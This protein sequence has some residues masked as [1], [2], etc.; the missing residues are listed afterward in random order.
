MLVKFKADTHQY[1]DENNN[2]L[3]SVSSFVKEFQ[4]KVDWIKKAKTKSKNLLKY[5]GIKKDYKEILKEWE[6]SRFLGTNAGTIIHAMKEAAAL[7]NSKIKVRGAHS[8]DFYKYSFDLS[9]LEDGYLYPELMMYDFEHMLCGQSDEVEILDGYINIYDYKT[10]KEILFK[11]YSNK[12]E[13]PKKLLAPVSHLDDCN[14]HIYTL[15][16][17]TYMYMVWKATKGKYKPGKIILKWCP[18]ERNELGHPILYNGVPKIVK[19]ENITLPYRKDE[20]IKMLKH[21]KK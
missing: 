16:M 4:E 21:I 9:E 11:G 20:V 2:E 3:I 17:S 7:N 19:E 10:D 8:D 12:W 5:E 1:F 18:I 15:K 14:G 13:G 6:Q